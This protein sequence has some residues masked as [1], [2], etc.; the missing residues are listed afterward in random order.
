MEQDNNSD[1]KP[2]WSKQRQTETNYKDKLFYS[3]LFKQNKTSVQNKKTAIFF[4]FT[5]TI[6][7]HQR[8]EQTLQNNVM[9]QNRFFISIQSKLFWSLTPPF[10]CY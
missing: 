9:K 7:M 5:A 10:L 1:E 8:T 3:K 6:N 2:A 4:V